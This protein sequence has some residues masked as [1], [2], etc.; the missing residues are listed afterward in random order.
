MAKRH[1]LPS[2]DALHAGGEGGSLLRKLLWT[3]MAVGAAA[4]ANAVIFTRRR[5]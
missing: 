3:G 2:D 1:R 5:R 4:I